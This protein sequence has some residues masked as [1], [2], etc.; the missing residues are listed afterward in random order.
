MYLI[1]GLGNPGL[2]YANTRHNVGFMAVDTIAKAKNVTFMKAEHRGLTATY[3]HQGQ[4]VM[5]VKPQTYM[6]LSGECVRAM[7]DYYQVELED[8]LV[9]Y[10]D[11]DLELGVLRIRKKG[12]AGTHNGMR[13]IIKE[14][15]CGDFPRI[16]FGIGKKP[17]QWDL[18]NFVLSR[19]TDEEQKKVEAMCQEAVEAVDYMIEDDIDVAMNRLNG[20]AKKS[21]AEKKTAEE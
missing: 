10:D 2:Q 20:K 21:R 7:A 18:A 14:L 13:S 9:I 8:V 4:K 3:F 11:I 1:I 16:R 5:L 15:G 12:S 19:L 6:N 17:P